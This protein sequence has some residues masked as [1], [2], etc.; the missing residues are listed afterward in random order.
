MRKESEGGQSIL[1]E[2]AYSGRKKGWSL[3]QLLIVGDGVGEF[4]LVSSLIYEF[5]LWI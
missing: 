2:G 5:S 3:N 1:Q 4:D